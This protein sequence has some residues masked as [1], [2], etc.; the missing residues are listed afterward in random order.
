METT[1]AERDTDPPAWTPAPGQV[2]YA[3]DFEIDAGDD[4][5]TDPASYA[6]LARVVIGLGGRL[7][8]VDLTDPYCPDSLHLPDGRGGFRPADGAYTAILP[9]DPA[10]HAP[11]LSEALRRQA[12]SD[13][14]YHTRQLAAARAV[15][16]LADELARRGR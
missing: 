10:H 14:A 7:G 9:F 8:V 3:A 11:T 1:D 15:L 12:E 4:T 6:E 5:L 2:V 16:A 13:I